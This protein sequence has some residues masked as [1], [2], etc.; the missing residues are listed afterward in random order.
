MIPRSMSW[1]TELPPWSPD[2]AGEAGLLLCVAP[3]SRGRGSGWPWSPG[4]PAAGGEGPSRSAALVST[5]SPHC[6]P[7]AGTPLTPG[8]GQREGRREY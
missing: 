5:S 2:W 7:A 1:K 3:H 8:G 4:S 6:E